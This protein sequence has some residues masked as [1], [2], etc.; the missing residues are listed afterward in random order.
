[1]IF[2]FLMLISSSGNH[3]FIFPVNGTYH[4]EKIRLWIDV[5]FI[6][7]LQQNRKKWAKKG[8]C[9]DNSILFTRV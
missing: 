9:F 5:N 3:T 1:M 2:V 4:T 8:C 7:L 6:K